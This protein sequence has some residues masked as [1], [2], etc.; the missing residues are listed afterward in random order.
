[1]DPHAFDQGLHHAHSDDSLQP[2]ISSP[3]NLPDH[4]NPLNDQGTGIHHNPLTDQ[5][6]LGIEQPSPLHSPVNQPLAD[7]PLDPTSLPGQ[8]LDVYQSSQMHS[9][10]NQHIVTEQFQQPNSLLAHHNQASH[11]LQSQALHQNHLLADSHL[12]GH[13]RQGF[14]SGAS[15]S[16]PSH[17]YDITTNKEVTFKDSS[18]YE[19]EGTVMDV[20]SSGDKYDIQ[21]SDGT[22]YNNIPYN[23]IEKYR[24]KS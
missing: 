14:V 23:D 11:H 5:P 7:S 21:T 1:M 12:G 8:H 4:H 22:T 10:H 20:H 3:Q 9:I 15:G 24:S 6:N 13:L 2:D 18:G 16:T 19:H 17:P